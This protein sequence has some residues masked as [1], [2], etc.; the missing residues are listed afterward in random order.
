[1]YRKIMCVPFIYVSLGLLWNPWDFIMQSLGCLTTY[2]LC[3]N[4]ENNTYSFTYSKDYEESK[5]RLQP[6]EKEK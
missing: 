2:S 5:G 1:M 6:E 3:Q 4:S